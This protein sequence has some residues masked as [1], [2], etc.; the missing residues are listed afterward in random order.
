MT[1]K[2][3]IERR[4]SRAGI[5]S[6]DLVKMTVANF[7]ERVDGEIARRDSE[8]RAADVA[9]HCSCVRMN[10]AIGIHDVGQQARANRYG[11]GFG[12]VSNTYSAD[13]SCTKC[14]GTGKKA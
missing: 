3:Q 12:L 5:S 8:R 11:M 13:K 4:A 14:G 1:A 7:A 10:S 9:T 6:L 2:E